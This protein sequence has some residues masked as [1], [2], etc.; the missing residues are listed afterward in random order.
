MYDWGE[1]VGRGRNSRALRVLPSPTVAA[2]LIAVLCVLTLWGIGRSLVGDRT[3]PPAS[4]DIREERHIGGGLLGQGEQSGYFL[5]SFGE[6]RGEGTQ[7]KQKEK[8]VSGGVEGTGGDTTQTDDD[9]AEI[10]VYVTGEVAAPRVVTLRRGA[11]VHEAIE[12]AGGLTA[13]A[14]P[15]SVNLARKL[16]DGEHILVRPLSSA[17]GSSSIDEEQTRQGKAAHGA[18]ECT[19]LR[20]ANGQELE[21]LDGVGPA[22]AARILAYRDSGGSLETLADLDA[23]PGIGPALLSRI[24]H[25]TC[26]Q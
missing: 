11:R 20:T 26:Q 12:K 10:T 4:G 25:Q 13:T 3:N 17:S 19:D 6:D 24:E 8:T 9:S 18:G 1:E 5:H 7:E 16:L 22:L 2:L 14:D 15:S 21:E 23:I